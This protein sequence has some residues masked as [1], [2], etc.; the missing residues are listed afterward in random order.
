MKKKVRMIAIDLDRT[1]LRDDKTIS[2]YSVKVLKE[3][4]ARGIIVAFATARSVDGSKRFV[5]QIKPDAVVNNG[6]SLVFAGDVVIYRRPMSVETT[7]TLLRLL[8]SAGKSVGYITTETN[9]GYFVNI[10]KEKYWTHSPPAIHVDFE[11][12]LDAEAFKV[13]AEVFDSEI[14]KAAISALPLINVIE[15]TGEEFV[16]FFDKEAGKLQGVTALATHYNIAL[17]EVAAFGDDYNDLEMLKGCGIGV[18]MDNAIDE[19]KAIADYICDTN[20]N[21]GVA[22][23]IWEN[24]FDS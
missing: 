19:A 4:Q 14:S 23:W 10:P 6:G 15:Y 3:C 21:D 11:K 7:N 20:E 2:E 18:A 8:H 5:E 22:K 1:L 24:L 13:V 16:Q 12:D 17:E 9:K